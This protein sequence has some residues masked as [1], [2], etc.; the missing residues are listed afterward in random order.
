MLVLYLDKG[1]YP[2]NSH[3][4]L[5]HNLN[6]VLFNLFCWQS[7]S[8]V[9]DILFLLSDQLDKDQYI[10]WATGDQTDVVGTMDHGS[11]YNYVDL[12]SMVSCRAYRK[13]SASEPGRQYIYP[14]SYRG[15]RLG[16]ALNRP[17]VA[18]RIVQCGYHCLGSDFGKCYPHCTVQII[19][20]LGA[21]GSFSVWSATEFWIMDFG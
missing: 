13:F 7:F 11:T 12:W 15:T 4:V 14:M 3:V 6:N 19:H 8:F 9:S 1:V 18:F 17:E 20:G 16:P 2:E 21:S 10:P 5:C